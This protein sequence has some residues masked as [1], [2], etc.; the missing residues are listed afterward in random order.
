M[1]STSDLPYSDLTKICI[2][3]MPP[4][5]Q[6]CQTCLDLNTSYRQPAR[7]WALTATDCFEKVYELRVSFESL[8]A[9]AALGCTKCMVLINGIRQSFREYCPSL[10]AVTWTASLISGEGCPLEVAIFASPDPGLYD[11]PELRI[12]FYS[13]LGMLF[14]S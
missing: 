7:G 14:R 4:S 2:P 9:A 10:E 5:P 6:P 11:K 1:N 8:S 12:Q 3:S 13:L